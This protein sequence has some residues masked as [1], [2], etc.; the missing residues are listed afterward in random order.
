MYYYSLFSLLKLKVAFPTC[1]WSIGVGVC[2]PGKV[3]DCPQGI[4]CS[5]APACCLSTL[6][7]KAYPLDEGELGSIYPSYCNYFGSACQIHS[8]TC[9]LH[10]SFQSLLYFHRCSHKPHM[11]CRRGK[12]CREPESL[13]N[14]KHF[15]HDVGRKRRSIFRLTFLEG[16][17]RSHL[18]TSCLHTWYPHRVEEEER[19]HQ[20]IY[21]STWSSLQDTQSPRMGCGACEG[22]CCCICLH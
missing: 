21:P 14:S 7:K 4:V 3:S 9:L 16:K 6:L 18:H 20:D 13:R 15:L 1:C 19:S 22:P 5:W 2:S 10:H 11:S 12:D 8:S 17:G